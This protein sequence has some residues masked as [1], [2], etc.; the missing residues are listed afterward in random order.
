[1]LLGVS[2]GE[3]PQNETFNFRTP[4]P[5]IGTKPKIENTKMAIKENNIAQGGNP[6]YGISNIGMTP[7]NF[8]S[9]QYGSSTIG[10]RQDIEEQIVN[11]SRRLR[12][13]KKKKQIVKIQVKKSKRNPKKK[14]LIVE[15]PKKKKKKMKY[16]SSL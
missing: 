1:M 3:L 4:S 6:S 7:S 13:N 10:D 9:K 12:T 15:K 16:K 2:K 5:S 14:V 11:R 8:N